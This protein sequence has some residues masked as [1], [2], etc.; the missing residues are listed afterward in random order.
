VVRVPRNIC[1]EKQAAEDDYTA[2]SIYLSLLL[3]DTMAAKVL[4]QLRRA[5]TKDFAAKD[6]L[7]ASQ[8]H[9]LKKGNDQVQKTLK[10]IK[11]GEAISP[12]LLVRGDA[13][14]GAT[15]TIADGYHRIC[16][17]WHWDENCPISCCVA[18]MPS[19]RGRGM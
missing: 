15:L 5:P 8:T 17:S 19:H 12:V 10:K 14:L 7:R 1:W 4:A 3:P 9:L 2:A 11:K 16:A 13:R 6:L 18:D